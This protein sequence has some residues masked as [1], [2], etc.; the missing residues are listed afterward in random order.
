MN[1]AATSLVSL[2]ALGA[3]VLAATPAEAA[4]VGSKALKVAAKQKGD[5][6]QYGAE[7]PT[8]FDCSGLTK[9]AFKKVGKKLPRTAQ[10][11]YNKSKKVSKKNRKPGHLVFFGGSK[12]VYH[13]GVY[14]GN[15]KVWHA[16]GKGKRVK[17]EKIW[18]TARYGSFN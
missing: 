14:A 2:A 8:R 17:L 1:R 9:Y 7:G 15:N 6:Y 18:T 10:A 12:S 4:S 13:V 5:W 3:V 16:P 11:Q